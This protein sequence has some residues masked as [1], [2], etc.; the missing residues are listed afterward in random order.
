MAD[1]LHLIL[2]LHIFCAV[3]YGG[4][5]CGCGIQ[6]LLMLRAGTE[7]GGRD[8]TPV[9]AMLCLG[10]PF[11]AG[12]LASGIR[13]AGGLQIGWSEQ[14]MTRAAFSLAASLALASLAAA[15][16]LIF[17]L[18]H[19]SLIAGLAAAAGFAGAWGLWIVALVSMLT[20]A[21]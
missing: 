7:A 6:I 13:L 16:S 10:F 20:K 17:A 2:P 3:C 15:A 21:A 14:W 5:L 1:L 8:L 4:I 9:A 12:T 19:R 18:R 11:G